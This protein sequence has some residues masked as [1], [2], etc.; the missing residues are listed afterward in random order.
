MSSATLVQAA[1]FTVGALVG[2][3]VTAALTVRKPALPP[4]PKPAPVVA[5]APVMQVG[6][7]GQAHIIAP[8]TSVNA[9]SLEPV[10][11]YGNPG[12]WHSARTGGPR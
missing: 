8:P 7:A 2:G 3:G 11:K 1:I 5:P 12:Q 4:P 10:L 9:G 6:P